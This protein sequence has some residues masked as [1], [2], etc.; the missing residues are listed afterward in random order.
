MKGDLLVVGVR[1]HV[2]LEAP[3][4]RVWA[5]RYK[6]VRTSND[7]QLRRSDAELEGDTTGLVELSFEHLEQFVIEC[8]RPHPT[9]SRLRWCHLWALSSWTGDGSLD[10]ESTSVEADVVELQTGEF[11]PKKTQRRR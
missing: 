6:W 2:V 7:E 10:I 1:R 4:Q 9:I 5:D 3:S 11:A 8:E